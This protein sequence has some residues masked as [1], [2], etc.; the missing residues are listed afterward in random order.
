[1]TRK[2]WITGMA[3]VLGALTARVDAEA[4]RGKVVDASG[5]AMEGVTVSAFD[6]ERQQSISVFSQADGSFRID[7]LRNV[8]FNEIGRASCRERV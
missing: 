6:K 5:K 7:G 8:K 1:M 4:I 2:L 3:L